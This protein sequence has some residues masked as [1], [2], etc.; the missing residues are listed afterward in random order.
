[1]RNAYAA[2][3]RV[4]QHLSCSIASQFICTVASSVYNLWHSREH[5]NGGN[6]SGSGA[7]FMYQP[8]I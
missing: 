2:T 4:I 8:A 7:F 6:M 5:A 1:M 3:N